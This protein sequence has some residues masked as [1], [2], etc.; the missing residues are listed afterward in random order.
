MAGAFQ[1]SNLSADVAQNLLIPYRK[2]C[3]NMQVCG[4]ES[5]GASLKILESVGKIMQNLLARYVFLT[6]NVVLNYYRLGRSGHLPAEEYE[7]I[8]ILATVSFTTI[9]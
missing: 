7:A 8:C 5:N 2:F 9:P 6:C 4:S 3:Q 1:I